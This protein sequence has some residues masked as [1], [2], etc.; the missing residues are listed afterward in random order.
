M[1]WPLAL[2][3]FFFTLGWTV[4]VI[5]LP[6]LLKLAGIDIS[7]LPWIL[8]VD[9]L[10]FA[11]ADLATGFWL[12]RSEEFLHRAGTWLTALVLAACALFVM[13]PIF[14]TSLAQAVPGLFVAALFVWVILSSVLRVPPLVLLAKFATPQHAAT[15]TTPVAAYLFGIGVAGALAPYLTVFLKSRDP[16]LPF[17]VASAALAVTTLALR[18]QLSKP[19]A[20][21][22]LVAPAMR[23][24]PAGKLTIRFPLIVAV[25]LF[26]FGMQIHAAINSARLF[27]RLAPELPLEWLMPLF[28]GAFSVT[29]F[30][31]ARWLARSADAAGNNAAAVSA[32]WGAGLIGG[33][34]LAVCATA[35][36]LPVLI[37]GQIVAG[38][39]WAL[40]FLAA[41]AMATELGRSGREGQWIGAF[42]ALLAV[43]TVGRI[44]LVL[45]VS[46]ADSGVFGK[47]IGGQLPW[48]S[49][50]SWLLGATVLWGWV[51]RRSETKI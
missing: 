3:Q 1:H 37:V 48:I 19:A 8:I 18:R 36:K 45:T 42:I 21:P 51:A 10:L 38:A 16:L 15:M 43:A 33:I 26:A 35:T 24:T 31:A 14:A 28:W 5:F 2:V 47:M 25:T 44:V 40:V 30:P 27:I 20:A 9:Q 41:I 23:S 50:V 7:W 11:A 6:G 13:L 29:M 22:A 17:V 34:A 32:L 4:Y 46:P 12:D 39:A 49:A